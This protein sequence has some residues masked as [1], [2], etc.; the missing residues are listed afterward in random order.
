[1]SS[2]STSSQRLKL[3]RSDYRTVNM[4][5]LLR[6]LARDESCCALPK[7]DIFVD[8]ESALPANEEVQLYQEAEDILIESE[9]IIKDLIGYKGASKEI[10]EAITKPTPE[11]EATAWTTLMPLVLKLK[12]FYD[13][14]LKLE[15][16]VPKILKE[17]CS[18]QKPATVVG[19]IVEQLDV[20]QALVKQFA[21]VLEFVLKFDEYKMM[22]PALQNDFSYYRRTTQ[23]NRNSM[24]VG[25]A[26]DGSEL[27]DPTQISEQISVGVAN[28]MSLFFANATPM[29]LSLSKATSQFVNDENVQDVTTEMLSVI[30]K[31]CQKMLTL[32]ELRSRLQYEETELFILR[33]MVAVVILYDHVHPTGA[34]AKGTHVDV[35]GCIK[36]LREQ[37]KSR[38][39]GLLNALR[40]TT[41][42]LNEETTPKSTKTLL[43]EEMA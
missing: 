29:L 24:N 21:K 9:G 12:S 15:S 2:L 30:A 16:V 36:V 7:H 25:A 17:L 27:A 43:F 35:K 23:R 20:H 8:F 40:Y 19:S 18:S 3:E 13:F 6:L 11:N 41:K 4:G 10:R 38:A 1:M 31:V 14:S 26:F 37:E 33:V 34:F 39:E 28:S 22:N 42:H 5:N 32:P